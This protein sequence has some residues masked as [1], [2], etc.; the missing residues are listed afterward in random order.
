[1][2]FRKLLFPL[3]ISYVIFQKATNRLWSLL[4]KSLFAE[5]GSNV[6]IGY[7]CSFSYSHIS[8]GCNIHI[9]EHSSFIATESNISIG[10]N[11]MFGPNVTIRGGD[12]RTDVIGEYM[13]NV[14]QK[15]PQNDKDVVICDDVWIGCNATILKGVTIGEGSII[16]AGS[17][18]VKNVPPY[19]IYTGTFPQKLRD[20]WDEDTI[21]RH[22]E[23]L[24]EKYGL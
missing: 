20:R 7:G 12:H 6:F 15:L 1:M 21:Q 13:F 3:A 18:V 17:L 22:K 10:N 5:C 23:I 14:K 2:N 4:Q 24:K 19:S 11:V 8:I 9:G 16:G